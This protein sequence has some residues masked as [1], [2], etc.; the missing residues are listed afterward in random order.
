[1]IKNKYAGSLIHEE[2]LGILRIAVENKDFLRVIQG[3][4]GSVL[5]TR[6]MYYY[7]S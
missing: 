2:V 4:C 3:F 6:I 5:N 1:M 7:L